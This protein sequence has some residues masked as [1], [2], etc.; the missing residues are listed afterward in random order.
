VS[1]G[2]T[3]S[4]IQSVLG[5]LGN[6]ARLHFAYE[7]SSMRNHLYPRLEEHAAEHSQ[8]MSDLMDLEGKSHR[9][10]VSRESIFF[11][12]NRLLEH[13][14]GSDREYASW[15]AKAGERPTVF[16]DVTQKR[17]KAISCFTTQGDQSDSVTL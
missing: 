9:V 17:R 7:E 8:F 12:E 10:K 15:L 4:A 5:Q 14:M 13:C 16:N 3:R 2:T 11:I 1:T 6:F